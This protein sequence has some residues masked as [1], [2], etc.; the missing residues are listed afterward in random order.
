MYI[1]NLMRS[2]PNGEGVNPYARYFKLRYLQLKSVSQASSQQSNKEWMPGQAASPVNKIGRPIF[3]STMGNGPV[4]RNQS[5]HVGAGPQCS[6][7]DT[8]IRKIKERP[9]EYFD[10]TWG[11]LEANLITTSWHHGLFYNF[12]GH[13]ENTMSNWINLLAIH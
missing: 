11:G 3:A 13:D 10:T 5:H 1:V 7:Q 12:R 2:V 9:S 4:C 8:G 6:L